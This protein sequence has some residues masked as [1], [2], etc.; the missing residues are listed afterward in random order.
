MLQVPNHN[1]VP[2][3]NSVANFGLSTPRLRNISP[4]KY[5]HIHVQ[6]LRSFFPTSCCQLVHTSSSCV[7]LH[8]VCC[9]LPLFFKLVTVFPSCV[10]LS[11]SVSSFVFSYFFFH[12]FLSTHP[13]TVVM[14]VLCIFFF[15]LFVLIVICVSG[16]LT[17]Q[18]LSLFQ[19]IQ[20][21]IIK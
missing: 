7:F 11:L 13:P 3:K 20:S 18:S 15:L 9:L 8:C 4:L 2:G 19:C 10:S 17:G 5:W 21:I 14:F 6:E 12:L 1:Q 16:G